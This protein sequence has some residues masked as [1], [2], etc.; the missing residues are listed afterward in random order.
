M[1][2]MI[3]KCMVF[4]VAV[5]SSCRVKSDFVTVKHVVYKG[6][7]YKLDIP[8]GYQFTGFEAGVENENIYLYPD[9]SHI[10]IT[11]FKHTPNANNIK[12]L[13]DSIF[14]LRFQNEDLLK[15]VNRSIGI[16][17][18][19]VLP[20]TFELLGVDKEGK[21]WKDVKIGKTTV[22]YSKVPEGK[23]PIYER[24]LSSFRRY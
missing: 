9:S 22:G 21:Y 17:V 7:I 10:Y 8:R 19:K 16:E 23:V 4:L 12:A 1:D 6:S 24:V 3:M 13:G 15:E 5:V 18:A 11:D 14:Q 2:Q 20:D